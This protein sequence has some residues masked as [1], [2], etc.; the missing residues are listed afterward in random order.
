M[1]IVNCT[2][3]STGENIVMNTLKENVTSY[4]SLKHYDCSV[5]HYFHSAL[6]RSGFL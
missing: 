1:S 4:I 6:L 3:Y 2:L 5:V